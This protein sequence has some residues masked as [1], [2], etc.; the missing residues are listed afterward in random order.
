MQKVQKALGYNRVTEIVIGILFSFACF[1]GYRWI[2]GVER[3]VNQVELAQGTNNLD[4]TVLKAENVVRWQ[5]II[6]KLESI[7]KRLS[8][9]E[10]RL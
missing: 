6:E 2:D 8:R 9:L 1:T 4:I 7:D 5:T 3:R 10:Q